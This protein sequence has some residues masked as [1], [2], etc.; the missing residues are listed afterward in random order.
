MLLFYKGNVYGT[1]DR[2]DRI[3]GAGSR[4]ETSGIDL[5]EKRNTFQGGY[6]KLVTKGVEYGYDEEGNLSRKTE[7]DGSVW[8][9]SY[10]GNGMLRKVVRPDR[11][12]VIF[13]YDALGRRIEKCIMKAGSEK[14]VSFAE[15][16]AAVKESKWETIG[17]V[18]I[19]KPDTE[20]VKLHVM[21][22]E[23]SSI[24][25][26]EVSAEPEKVVHFLWDGNTILHEWEDDSNRSRKPQPK[27]DYQADYVVKLSEQKKQ[28]SKAKAAK[29]EPT[30]ETLV[31]WVFQDDFI[32]RAKITKDGCYSIMT[33]YLGTPVEAYDE[34]GNLVWERE[35]DINGKVL[36][37]GKDSY[38][39]TKNEV[40]E[41]T[42]IPFR[43]QGQYEDEEI[44]LY[45]N[46]FRYYDP[47]T[48]Q[49][50]QQDPI[51]LVGENPTLYGYV[52]DTL[53]ETDPFGLTWKDLLASGLGHHL[54][55]RSVA[56]KLDISQ[57]AKLTA[58]S[59]YPNVTDGSGE[60]HQLLH[61]LLRDEGIP[62]HGSKFTGDIDDFFKKAIKAYDKLDGP[63]YKGYLKIPGTNDVAEE[64]MN[65]TP[66]EGLEKIRDLLK[67]GELD[68]IVPCKLK[69]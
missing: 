24:Y 3:Y 17:G 13:K 40:G 1:E 38:G 49:Y 21:Q 59:W 5:K 23:T 20:P 44:G 34:A 61:K 46:R 52:Y 41:S 29:G 50:T 47:Q 12:A 32:P 25:S 55:P 35:I 6:G 15:K 69:S 57:L 16:K 58:L 10:Y 65:L 14:I 19:R 8:E 37:V 45:Y 30:P 68:M 42:F 60:L 56:K 27:I 9:Y 48:G 43:F 54:F 62:F 31:T 26:E 53:N 63:E 4:L 7:A 18:R 39:R 22:G 33:D 11:S 28:E 64:L 51:G 66:K 36:P 2:S 67:S